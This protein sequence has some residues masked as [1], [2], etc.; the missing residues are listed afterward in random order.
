[1]NVVTMSDVHDLV[2][3]EGDYCVSLYLTTHPTG[4]DGMQDEVRL[5]NL[6]V[7]ATDRL[8]ELGMRSVS[9]REFLAPLNELP[10]IDEWSQRKLGL[11][12]FHSKTACR[13]FWLNT[14][15]DECVVVARRYYVRPLLPAVDLNAG[16]Y[17][18]ALSRNHVRL[19]K[20]TASSFSKLS[21]PGFPTSMEMALNLQGAE[22]GEQVHTGMHAHVGKEAGV[23]HGQ[24][25]HRDTIKEE[26][27]EYCQLITK[28][29]APIL[30]EQPLP[31]I[32]AGVGYELELFRQT[33]EYGNFVDDELT[34]NF[35]IA[36]D[37]ALYE[38]ALP[39]AK[40]HYDALRQK[41]LVKYQTMS[42][43]L[44]TSE[45]MEEIIPAAHQGK[46]DTLLVDPRAEVFGRF[47]E[48]TRRLEVV[49]G[50]VPALDLVELAVQQTILHRGY[51]YA[52]TPEELPAGTPMCAILRY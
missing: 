7:A 37:H 15:F 10:L 44:L 30:R 19:L 4:R 28:S 1:M 18:L 8:V 17:V 49:R 13:R 6:V 43:R 9:A 41:P 29:L 33:C 46:V 47:D 31:V 23:Y 25:G 35:D 22:R 39:V 26:V 5:K 48:N 45:N 14:S 36:T 20:A 27:V 16:F 42:E 51:V 38:L 12:V 52:A 11:A 40:R 34:G 32:L 3:V 2:S 21:P 50:C 24:G